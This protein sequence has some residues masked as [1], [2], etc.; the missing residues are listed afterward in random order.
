MTERQAVEQRFW[1]KVWQCSHRHPCKRCCWPWRS[2]D[3][4]VNWKCVWGVH[5]GFT[6]SKYGSVSSM[7][8]PRFAYELAYGRVLFTGHGL[9]VC[10]QCHFG[11]CCNYAHMRPGSASDN[12]SDTR[13]ARHRP[14]I[15]RLPDGRV[16][17]Y[18]AACAA[19][20]AFYAARGLL[21]VFAG[22]V[23]PHFV[24]MLPDL[25]RPGLTW[26]PWEM[27]RANAL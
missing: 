14:R 18:Q 24:H 17:D 16:W 21:H 26:V 27:R 8:A 22:P 23:H 13:A 25:D 2:I 11:P 19:Q 1:A 6:F 15:I 9:H 5:P 3:L 4:S 7:T 12:A 10:H 20:D